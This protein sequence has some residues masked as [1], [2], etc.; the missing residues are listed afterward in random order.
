MLA[1]AAHVR[2]LAVTEDEEWLAVGYRS[3]ENKPSVKMYKIHGS[4]LTESANVSYTGLE[5]VSND[6]VSVNLHL[7]SAETIFITAIA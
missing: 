6:F 3:Y 5:D 7:R 4:K 1:E 2:C